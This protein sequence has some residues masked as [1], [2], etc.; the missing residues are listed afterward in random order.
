MKVTVKSVYGTINNGFKE[1]EI[2]GC[3]G[4]TAESKKAAMEKKCTA[5]KLDRNCCNS[6][7]KCGIG[8]GDCDSDTD[9]K[10][11]LVCYH[12]TNNCKKFDNRWL[13]W[14]DCCAE[15]VAGKWLGL[16]CGKPDGC[17]VGWET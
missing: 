17:N 12:E 7:Y 11:G 3:S 10:P 4:G 6:H 2:N 15:P 14:F 5:D 13:N 9:C 16:L 8:G 1:I